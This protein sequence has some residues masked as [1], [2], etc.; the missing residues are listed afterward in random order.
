MILKFTQKLTFLLAFIVQLSFAQEKTI[1]GNVT[2][3]Q[4]MSL[5]GANIV[6]K[7]TSTGTQ[8]DFDGNYS[9]TVG[10]GQVLQFTYVGMATAERT[11]GTSATIDLR[12]EED[13]QALEEVIV[14][15][16]GEQS[17]RAIVGSVAKID[18]QV[19]ETQQLTD[20][21]T[22]IR[23]SVP[24]DNPVITRPSRTWYRVH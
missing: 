5:P 1:T 7:G 12:M 18:S 14:V 11:V 4:G 16:Y 15:A 2:D 20:V 8:T 9:I 22:A 3:G 23:G 21:T 24:A 6:V 10:V 19:I 17:E 13:A